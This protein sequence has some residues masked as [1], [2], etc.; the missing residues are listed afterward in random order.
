MSY[1]LRC[2]NFSN[3]ENDDDNAQSYEFY[4]KP[5]TELLLASL[6]FDTAVNTAREVKYSMLV[7]LWYAPRNGGEWVVVFET[8]VY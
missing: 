1:I 4:D 7:Q 5:F 6:A 2:H 8:N 3:Q